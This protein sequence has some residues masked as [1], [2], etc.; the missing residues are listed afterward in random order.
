MLGEGAGRKES[1]LINSVKYEQMPWSKRHWKSEAPFV[2]LCSHMTHRLLASRLT[3]QQF[4]GLSKEI[5]MISNFY[6]T[7]YSQNLTSGLNAISLDENVAGVLRTRGW[8]AVVWEAERVCWEKHAKQMISEKQVRNERTL[9]KFLTVL[10]PQGTPC[11]D[12]AACQ[13]SPAAFS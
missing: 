7:C 11:R 13:R 10:L 3:Y 12:T 4:S 2:G 8:Q 1:M 9:P 6:L 5:L